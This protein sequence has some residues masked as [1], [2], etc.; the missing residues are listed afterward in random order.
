MSVETLLASLAV[1]VALILIVRRF[2]GGRYGQLL[3]ND[4]ATADYESFLV[5]PDLRYY[6]SGPDLCPN[7]IMGVAK[8]WELDSDLWKQR[9]LEPEG[10]RELVASMQ[11]RAGQSLSLLH[12]FAIYDD[13]GGR[14]GNWFSL[15]GLP[16]TIKITG[17]HRVAI[18]TPSVDTSSAP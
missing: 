8:T 4:Q 13:K 10:M 7:A 9:D 17:E 5:N 11:A 2:S 1:A 12:G 6:L 14:I 18:S 3:P 16:V 15:P